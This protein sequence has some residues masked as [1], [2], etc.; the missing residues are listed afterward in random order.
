MPLKWHFG[1]VGK[2]LAFITNVAGEYTLSLSV[3][4]PY[5]H[6]HSDGPLTALSPST[7]RAIDVPFVPKCAHNTFKFHVK[8]DGTLRSQWR[9]LTDPPLLPTK[10]IDASRVRLSSIVLDE[11]ISVTVGGERDRRA[12]A[13][14]TAEGSLPP[15]ERLRVEWVPM[16]EDL[17]TEGLGIRRFRREVVMGA[18]KVTAVEQRAQIAVA[19]DGMRVSTVLD[20]TMDRSGCGILMPCLLELAVADLSEPPNGNTGA[21]ARSAVNVVKVEGEAVGHWWLAGD[22]KSFDQHEEEQQQAQSPGSRRSSHASPSDKSR[23]KLGRWH[24]PRLPIANGSSEDDADDETFYR[25]PPDIHKTPERGGG[26]SSI[27][28]PKPAVNLANAVSSWSTRTLMDDFTRSGVAQSGLED[29]SSGESELMRANGILRRRSDSSSLGSFIGKQHPSEGD[30]LA[31]GQS[32]TEEDNE[33]AKEQ[34][35]DEKQEVE[36]EAEVE[37]EDDA[38]TEVPLHQSPIPTIGKSLMEEI[39][40]VTRTS[41]TF[42]TD[43]VSS[44]RTAGSSF[45]T[46]YVRLDTSKLKGRGPMVST[47]ITVD[48]EMVYFVTEHDGA[49]THGELHGSKGLQ[50]RLDGVLVPMV[51][52]R[53]SGGDEESASVRRSGTVVVRAPRDIDVQESKRVGL[54]KDIDIAEAL[55]ITAPTADDRGGFETLAKRGGRPILAYRHSALMSWED[56]SDDVDEEKVPRLHLN[57]VRHGVV[58]EGEKMI[59]IIAQGLVRVTLIDEPDSSVRRQHPEALESRKRAIVR[60]RFDLR[61]P[62]VGDGVEHLAIR[63]PVPSAMVSKVFAFVDGERVDVLRSGEEEGI[64]YRGVGDAWKIPLSDDDTE[65]VV[66]R[67]RTVKMV[68]IELGYVVAA[69]WVWRSVN[70]EQTQVTE[71]E[72]AK[73]EEE[74]QDERQETEGGVLVNLPLPVVLNALMEL[75][76]V[77][78]GTVEG[79][80]CLIFALC[81]SS[82]VSVV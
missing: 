79:K 59:P 52:C 60:A 43:M 54:H 41:K 75:Y 48:T 27:L 77:D 5:A 24:S 46:I 44:T 72:S 65:R 15:A 64:G 23:K 53:V 21:E 51:H 74:D 11:K 68:E 61:D 30:L 40:T 80:L 36:A 70:R 22:I 73:N 32:G 6:T 29:S 34:E 9:I 50:N 58:D 38:D 25:D 81:G 78:V 49:L 47:R 35:E 76:K 26:Q 69:E 13:V 20:I 16:V 57:V 1:I 17:V 12:A 63:V 28:A 19:A 45:T 67:K 55:T 71:F 82:G 37:I 2:T 42:A 10:A 39:Q 31:F 8:E 62:F 33:Q 3:L 4:V 56:V 14:D 7:V 18:A 66:G